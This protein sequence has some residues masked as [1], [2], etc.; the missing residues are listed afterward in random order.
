MGHF[1]L[2]W[3]LESDSRLQPLKVKPRCSVSPQIVV[4]FDPSYVSS[5]EH[6]TVAAAVAGTPNL[7]Q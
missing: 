6:E 4:F 1:V 2:L 5:L 7:P 3:D